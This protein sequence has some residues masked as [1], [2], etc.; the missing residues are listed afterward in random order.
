MRTAEIIG[1]HLYHG[2]VIDLGTQYHGIIPVNE[3]QWPDL[4]DTLT[5]EKQVRVRVHAVRPLKP[6]DWIFFCAHLLI[7]SCIY[8]RLRLPIDGPTQVVFHQPTAL[9]EH[10]S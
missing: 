2:A 9:Q 3:S 7:T 4:N 6:L 5:L 10:Q 8:S 1:I